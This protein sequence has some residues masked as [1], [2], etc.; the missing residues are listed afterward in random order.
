M[1]EP[2]SSSVL[3]R[4]AGSRVDRRRLKDFAQ[5]LESEVTAGRPFVCMITDDRE[6]RRLNRAFRQQDE[7]TDVLSFPESDGAGLLGEMAISVDRAREQGSRYGHSQAE[8]LDILM[9][10]GVLHLMGMDHERDRGAMRRAETR[11]RKIL[12]LPSGLIERAAPT[13]RTRK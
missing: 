9:L 5:R 4:R 8:E 2:P 13:E 6:L 1:N 12:G 7:P 3:F 10:H 11:W